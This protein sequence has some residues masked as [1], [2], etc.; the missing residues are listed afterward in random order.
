MRTNLGLMESP[1]D[2]GDGLVLRHA[3]KRDIKPL[4]EMQAHAFANPDTGELD[5]YLAGWTSDLMSGKHPTFKP[6]DFLVVEDTRTGKMVSCSCLISQTWSMGAISFGVG[7]VEIVGTLAEYRRRG[8]VREQFK[9]LHQMSAARGELVQSIT[10]IPFYYRQFGY[11]FALDLVGMR[12]TPVPQMVPELK[13]GAKEE[14]RLR[15]ATQDDLSF[16]TRMYAN[17]RQR[18]LVHCERDRERIEF[19]QFHEY[20]HLNGAV[21]WWD[22]IE[23]AQGERAGIL[24]H[25]RYVY[26]GRHTIP[27]F[28]ILP[29]FSWEQVIPAVVREVAG[30][31]RRMKPEDGKPLERL[32]WLLASNH[33]LYQIKGEV[34]APLSEP[35]G[36][37]IR[38]TD[39]PAFLER[40]GPLLEQ[41][42]V[43]SNYRNYTGSLRI[44]SYPNG[45]EMDWRRGKLVSAKPWRAT[46]GDFGQKGFGDAAFPNLT[47]LKLLFGYRSRSELFAMYPDALVNEEKTNGLIDALFPKLPSHVMPLH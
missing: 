19:E 38:M 43:C 29:K 17:G 25:R 12:Q 5:I 13:K 31:A 20:H 33:P 40:I 46:A 11:E 24:L 27:C 41:R 10:G 45:F 18:S 15:R 1:Q 4:G 26:R 37:Y 34:T 2:L 47:F 7:R 22:I 14:F 35:Y 44:H 21:S 8:L 36:W 3:T 30:Q 9:I 6:H 42:L 28:E 32:G 23:T 16:V 39:V